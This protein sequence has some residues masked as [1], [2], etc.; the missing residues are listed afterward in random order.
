MKYLFAMRGC[1]SNTTFIASS[2]GYGIYFNNL[3]KYSY[4]WT[5]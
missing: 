3:I 2:D 5:P 1:C 4:I